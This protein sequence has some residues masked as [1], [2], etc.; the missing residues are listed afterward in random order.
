MFNSHKGT[1]VIKT[2][3]NWVQ[4]WTRI[5]LPDADITIASLNSL[6]DLALDFI[7]VIFIFS[8]PGGKYVKCAL[9]KSVYGNSRWSKHTKKCVVKKNFTSNHRH[10]MTWSGVNDDKQSI[11]LNYQNKFEWF[12]WL[13]SEM[14][15]TSP[16]LM[17]LT[18]WVAVSVA[19]RVGGTP[20]T[21]AIP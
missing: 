5:I 9:S 8:L 13:I 7:I 1:Y 18:L 11:T 16:D 15:H 17:R 19:S 12:N 4:K 10:W 2:L 3:C 6:R 14:L 21:K 20:S